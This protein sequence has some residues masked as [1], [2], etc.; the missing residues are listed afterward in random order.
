MRKYSYT[1]ML[2]VSIVVAALFFGGL[3]EGTILRAFFD[4]NN[5]TDY[6]SVEEPLA[7]KPVIYI[8][9]EKKH[10]QMVETEPIS[11][12]ETVLKNITDKSDELSADAPDETLSETTETTRSTAASETPTAPADWNFEDSLF[13]GD[14]RTVGLAEYADMGGADIYASSGMSVFKI[15]EGQLTL[16]GNSHGKEKQTLEEVLTGKEYKNIFL[17]LGINELGYE[18]GRSTRKYQEVVEKIQLLQ[19]N[20]VIYLQANLH[21]TKK[22]STFDAIYNNTNID[23]FNQFVKDLT[24]GSS[25][26]YLDINQQFDDGAGNLASEYTADDSHVLGRYYASWAEWIR[27]QAAGGPRQ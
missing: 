16:K 21:V 20:A 9:N 18:F 12:T 5:Q 19:P 8:D 3:K 4:I 1:L 25:R 6:A 24:D 14:S 11:E 15:F 27:Q 26:I 10:D 13:I 7:E 17:M 23:Q 22:K 2:S